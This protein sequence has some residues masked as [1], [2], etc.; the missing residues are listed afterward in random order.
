MCGPGF[1][2]VHRHAGPTQ[3]TA[4]VGAAESASPAISNI[5]APM[6][7][8]CVPAMKTAIA[9]PTISH[10]RHWQPL[11]ESPKKERRVTEPSVSHIRCGSTTHIASHV[12]QC[13]QY[14]HLRQPQVH[15]S[16]DEPLS[17]Q[18]G[19]FC[20]KRSTHILSPHDT[21]TT[22]KPLAAALAGLTL[23]TT[24]I[25]LAPNLDIF[26]PCTPT[27]RGGNVWGD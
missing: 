7:G 21:H 13:T 2:Y 3:R 15:R 8:D 5:G 11:G 22:A 27:E 20:D 14:M 12:T 19:E 26:A 10:P 24:N 18:H 25:N 9:A 1:C 6:T 4:I 17:E 23:T 16:N